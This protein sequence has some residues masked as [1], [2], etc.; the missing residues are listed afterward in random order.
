MRYALTIIYN[1]KHH[2][3]HNNYYQTIIDNFDK[4]AIIEGFSN[5]NGSSSWCN[6]IK[7]NPQS[8]DGTIEFIEE[9]KKL[10]PNKILFKTSE[11]GWKSKDE[12]SNA[13][14]DLLQNLPE[15]WLWNIDADEQWASDDFA[16]AESMLEKNIETAGAFKFIH[17][18]CKDAEGNQLI[19]GGDWGDNIVDRLWWFKGQKFLRHVGPIM[20]G[21]KNRKLLPIK[22][23][24]YS[25][26][27]EQDVIFKSKYYRGYHS[28]H[29]NW[30]NIQ[31]KKYKYPISVTELLGNQTSV[32]VKHSYITT[33]S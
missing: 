32:N 13:G 19:G 29:K 1:G 15:S 8:T 22:Y 9:L 33:L 12:Q 25:Y 24:H 16:L 21:Q 7:V 14:I 11:K 4:W 28:V 17:Y 23:H 2:L 6:K 3:L 27:F 10:Y 20:E 31:N 5:N 26:Y 18:L 30:K